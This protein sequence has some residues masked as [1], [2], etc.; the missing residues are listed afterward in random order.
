MQKPIKVNGIMMHGVRW[1]KA[2]K[3]KGSR[4]AGWR[5]LRQY[6]M[7]A[8]YQTHI[9]EGKRVTI[10]REFPGLFVFDHCVDF[11]KHFPVLPRDAVNND[12]VDTEAEDHIGDEVRYFVSSRK[13]KF[14][15]RTEGL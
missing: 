15:N 6:L 8:K 1:V 3:E 12:D 7:N 2:K 13:P 5:K 11:I 9:E 4:I 10:P 14:S